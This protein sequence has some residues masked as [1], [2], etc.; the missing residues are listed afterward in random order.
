MSEETNQGTKA[1]AKPFLQ[2]VSGNPSD[3]EVAALTMV[4]AGLAKSAAAQ[5]ASTSYDRNQW[6]NL[7]ERLSRPTTFNP[8]AFQNVNFF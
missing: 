5:Q 7:T 6:G 2:I 4:F 3:Q 8:S 1:A